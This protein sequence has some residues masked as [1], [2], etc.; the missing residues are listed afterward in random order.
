MKRKVVL[1]TTLLFVSALSA[2]TQNANEGESTE[3]SQTTEI[4]SDSE[5]VSESESESDSGI[6]TEQPSETEKEFTVTEI[7]PDK[8]MDYKGKELLMSFDAPSEFDVGKI[9]LNYGNA[10]YKSEFDAEWMTNGYLIGIDDTSFYV[11]LQACYSNDWVTSFIV[12]YDGNSFIDIAEQDGSIVDTSSITREQIVFETR[13]DLF[14]TYG[15]TVPMKF[16]NDKLTS[17]DTVIK[18][19]NNPDPSVFEG[20]ED[21]D[22][23]SKEM[24][25]NLYN[26]EGYRVLT[27]KKSLN[28]TSE[29]GNLEISVGEQIIP[30]GYDESAQKFYFTYNDTLYFFEYEASD[31]GF[32]LT[33]NGVDQFDIFEELPYAG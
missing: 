24:L 18:F 25:K 27:L 4:E 32:Y 22:A 13:V 26:K 10:N 31:E 5:S 21:L 7:E 29:T 3:P 17:L 30:Y 19:V 1:I 2:C 9:V 12:K 33:I 11:I 8:K 20:L 6:P 16:E 28:A 14:G 15:I 23:D